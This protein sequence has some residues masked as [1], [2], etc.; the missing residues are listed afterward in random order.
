M[1]S[2]EQIE[3]LINAVWKAHDFILS[4]YRE[5]NPEKGQLI[6]SGALEVWEAL[7]DAIDAALD[8]LETDPEKIYAEMER[9][10]GI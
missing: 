5:T 10:G 6:E 1:M 3:V 4:E 2:E 8:G 7:C 9:N